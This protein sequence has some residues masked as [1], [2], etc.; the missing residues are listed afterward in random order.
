MNNL[1]FTPRIPRGMSG[2]EPVNDIIDSLIST[3]QS[4]T[5]ITAAA[6][7]PVQAVAAALTTALTG[8]NN[9]LVFTAKTKG[10]AGE[11]ITIAYV[12]PGEDAEAEVV[13]VTGTA[14]SVTLRSATSVLSTATQVK[15]AIEATPAAAALVSVANAAANTGAGS[16]TAM[17]ATAL[18][19][20]VDGTV[21]GPFEQ[22]IHSGYLYI[23]NSATGNSVSDDNWYRVQLTKVS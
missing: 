3:L 23:A 15:A 19:G 8:D 11:A 5:E 20:G 2:T 22:V 10:T 18:D 21:G 14:I 1:T 12:D 4:H 9:D 17:A 13:T 6:S 7:A 16:V